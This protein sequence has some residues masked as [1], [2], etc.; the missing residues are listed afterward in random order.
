MNKP[1]QTIGLAS[2]IVVLVGC[3][4][5]RTDAGSTTPA[6]TTPY[7]TV[8]SPDDTSLPPAAPPVGSPP[9]TSTGGT[10]PVPAATPVI[11]RTAADVPR[12][13]PAEAWQL[14]ESGWAVLIDTRSA[15]EYRAGHAA[16]AISLPEADAAWRYAELPIDRTLIFY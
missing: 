8:G 13:S 11:V 3:G 5:S 9:A 1:L 6:P 14:L 10:T 16:D 15:E 12:I 2:L 4:P 7:V